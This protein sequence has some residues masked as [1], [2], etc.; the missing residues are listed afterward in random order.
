[1][2]SVFSIKDRSE[3]WT[4]KKAFSETSILDAMQLLTS[5]WSEVSEATIKKGFTKVG[6]SKKSAE[7]A[8]NDQDDVF[9][10]LTAEE[11]EETINKFRERFSNEVVEKL[12]AAV[13]LDMDTE[14]SANAD[15]PS[16]AEILVEVQGE[17]I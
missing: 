14:L 17:A 13:L 6:I 4:W 1:M 12:N 16:D 2:N 8:I 9:K 10:H 7:E 5:A 15:K 3:K 11:L